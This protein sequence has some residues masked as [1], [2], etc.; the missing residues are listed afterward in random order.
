MP[1]KIRLQLYNSNIYKICHFNILLIIFMNFSSIKSFDFLR[2][3]TLRSGNAILLNEKGAYFYNTQ[4][5]EEI[6]LYDTTL[7]KNKTTDYEFTDLKQFPSDGFIIFRLKEKFYFI[8]NEKYYQCKTDISNLQTLP[9]I[10]IFPIKNEN[11]EKYTFGIAYSYPQFYMNIYEIT[12]NE[13]NCN[14]INIK[15]MTHI[16]TNS[17]NTPTETSD[18]GAVCGMMYYSILGYDIIT[19]FY[20]LSFP[21]ELSSTFFDIN[22]DYQEI[23]NLRAYYNWDY[24]TIVIRGLI[25]DEK[26]KAI[27]CTFYGDTKVYCI[28]YDINKKEF[29]NS[30]NVMESK[31]VYMYSWD[32]IYI[33][34]ND[35]YVISGVIDNTYFFIRLNENFEIINEY[36]NKTNCKFEITTDCDILQG[37]ALIYSDNKYYYLSSIIIGKIS[38]VNLT[39]IKNLCNAQS[40]VDIKFYN[41][42]TNDSDSEQI[43]IE[44]EI[45]NIEYEEVLEQTE[46]EEEEEQILKEKEIIDEE[47]S[48]EVEK[49]EIEEIYLNKLIEKEEEIEEHEKEEG[50]EKEK[51]KKENERDEE[52]KEIYEEEKEIEKQEKEEEKE[53]EK[54][55]KEKEKIEEIKEIYEEENE[56]KVEKIKNIEEKEE[57][58]MVPDDNKNVII[59]ID[60]NKTKEY[61]VQNLDKFL[62]DIEIGKVYKISGEDFEIIISPINYTKQNKST[63]IDFRECGEILKKKYNLSEDD[64]LTLF[65]IEIEKK[66]NQKTLTDQV[67]YAILD[68]EKNRL[69]LSYCKNVSIIVNY[70]IKNN[71]LLNTDL[72]NYYNQQGVDILN[73]K[74]D[75]FN[76]LC[77]PYGENNTDIILEDR[78]ED[79][80]QN[81]SKCDNGCEYKNFNVETMIISCEC[82]IKENITSEVE[83]TTFAQV[84]K[85]TFKNSNF[86]VIRCYKLLLGFDKIKSNMGFWVFL[87]LTLIHLP[88]IIHYLINGITSI[89][90]YI[91]Y[92]MKNN[93]YYTSEIKSNPPLKINKFNKNLKSNVIKKN[94][95]ENRV[96]MPVNRINDKSISATMRQLLSP[97]DLFNFKKPIDSKDKKIKNKKNCKNY[98]IDLNKNSSKGDCRN[99]NQYFN[100]KNSDICINNNYRKKN[101][102]LVILNYNHNCINMDCRDYK[103]AGTE[104]YKIQKNILN[105][106]ENKIQN[107]SGRQLNDFDCPRKKKIN[108]NK[109]NE[110][111]EKIERKNYKDYCIIIKMDANNHHKKKD[112]YE[113][114]YILDNYEYKEAIKYET[115][116]FWRIFLICLLYKENLLNTFFFKSPL[117]L[118]T[119]RICLFIFH[120][121]CDFALNAL[122]Y[123]NGNISDRYHYVGSSLYFY[124]FI[125]NIV[126]SVCSTLVSYF[127]AI[128]FRYLIY[129][130]KEIRN[131]F[132]KEEY[133]MKKNKKYF[134]KESSK[135]KI[136][137]E[138]ERIYKKLKIKIAIFLVMEFSLMI[139]FWYYV[140]TFCAVY[141]ETQESW[142]IDSFTSL[143]F[144]ILVKFIVCLFLSSLYISAV[145][146]KIKILYVIIIFVYDLG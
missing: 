93:N 112:L 123:L 133:K 132:R 88:L 111:K 142:L 122:F 114:K 79:I 138:I 141:K 10:S 67:E 99:S 30:V 11:S 105:K 134:V 96:S 139:F 16:P 103:K 60:S 77:H 38:T 27:I 83:E 33:S 15:S 36:S 117:L 1:G 107:E 23:S 47:E 72:I 66:N 39:E 145:R 32:L 12:P 48:E 113:S 146:H 127:L 110:I 6:F 29:S 22:N 64:L 20:L 35:Q 40:N 71:S 45:E 19:C 28:I 128:L 124:S 51:F 76:N 55:K 31:M 136:I 125:N 81:Y 18:D 5:E 53:K 95:K 129:S 43:I 49:M 56:E 59:Y 92:E 58:E 13:E 106:G 102:P 80:Y 54:F 140:S 57:E 52:L 26:T 86:G 108:N 50:K 8:K 65:Q 144:S 63:S 74:D 37:N 24:S 62:E 116:N 42:T 3:Y 9:Y 118:K 115:R 121:S 69:N 70:E 135:N 89:K 73:I 25:N 78:V 75:F 61:I 7:L 87:I 68:Q 143:L 90:F 98:N 14:L 82:Q 104:Y 119:L 85:Q 17:Y 2:S 101:Q 34:T 126:I 97:F 109:N 100:K 41:K 4:T 46:N 44:E 94:N 131:V 137:H 120:Y 130:K 91:T 21:A 84:V